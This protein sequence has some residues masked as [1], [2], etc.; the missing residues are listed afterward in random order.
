MIG[1]KGVCFSNCLNTQFERGPFLR[2][3]GAIPEGAIAK[4]FVW[5]VGDELTEVPE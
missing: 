5:S 3:L 2:D 4:K 1:S